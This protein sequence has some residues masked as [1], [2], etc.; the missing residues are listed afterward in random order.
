MRSKLFGD[1]GDLSFQTVDSRFSIQQQYG[2]KKFEGTFFKVT[3][4]EKT[5]SIDLQCVFI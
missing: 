1:P 4:G 5:H 3:F 2:W